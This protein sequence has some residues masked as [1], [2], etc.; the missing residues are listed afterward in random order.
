MGFIHGTDSLHMRVGQEGRVRTKKE[1]EKQALE[2][3]N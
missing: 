2:T 3:G 1:K